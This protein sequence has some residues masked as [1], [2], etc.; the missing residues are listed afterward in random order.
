VR[1]AAGLLAL[2]ALAGCGGHG[3]SGS[4]TPAP[5]PSRRAGGDRP[6]S[7]REQLQ[8]LLARRA[9]A[10][11]AGAPAAYAATA[12][13]RQ[14]RRDRR[15]ARI[16][17]RL[18]LRS[19]GLR[20]DAVRLDGSRATL[21]V[22]A[23]YR[24]R[25][26]PDEFSGTRT[27]RAVRGAA[28]WRISAAGG[29]RGRAPWEV[30]DY[31]RRRLAHFTLLVPRGLDVTAAGMPEALEGGYAAIRRALPHARLRGRYVV[32][33]APTAAAATA[34]TTDIRG[35]SG[36]AAISDI[37]VRETGPARRVTD[38]GAQRLLV[39]WPA[40]SALAPEEGRRVVTHELTHAVLAGSTS[41]RTPSWLV[42]GIALYASGDRRADQVAAALAGRAGETGRRARAAFSLRALS[43]PDA[44]ARL[45]GALQSGAYAYASA[46]A[47]T[48]AGRYGRPALLD[49]YDAFNDERLP[50]RPGPALVDR[51]LRRT[52]GEGIDAFDAQVRDAA[53]AG[54][55]GR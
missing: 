36:L 23:G 47:F 52:I 26:T 32:V 4:A 50:G 31:G 5:S 51:A 48:L 43:A 42:E 45:R 38:V 22:V 24:L 2:L 21:R 3:A 53:A 27:L 13:G 8:S 12:T 1:R 11:A 30:A 9:R 6:P 49:L 35:V 17:A 39:I 34:L 44:I 20:L 40:F 46:A 25:G 14:R 19:A 37:A 10:L 18:G 15:A 54:A 29:P 33:V 28:G 55:A 7:D 41:G 16:A